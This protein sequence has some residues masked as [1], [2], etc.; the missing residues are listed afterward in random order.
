[1][2]PAAT[3]AR[4]SSAIITKPELAMLTL[5]SL[6]Q[7]W[8]HCQD[9]ANHESIESAEHYFLARAAFAFIAKTETATWHLSLRNHGGAALHIY[10]PSISTKIH[11]YDQSISTHQDPY[12]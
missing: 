2:L 5:P 1:M 3:Q 4:A 6:G 10:D 7:P 8:F 9:G 11:I 12:L